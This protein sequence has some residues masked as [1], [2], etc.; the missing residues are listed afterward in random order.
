MEAAVPVPVRETVWGLPLALSA[1]LSVAVRAPMAAGVKVKSTVALAFGATLM[2]DAVVDANSA[3]LAPVIEMLEI[4][5]FAFPVLVMVTDLA[6]PVV[7]TNCCPNVMLAGLRLALGAVPV[8]ESVTACGLPAALSVTV[9]SA[10]SE[11]PVE[12]VNVTAIVVFAPGRTVT[13]NVA[14]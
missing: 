5:R 7:P 6:A 12:G 10:D 3:A 1:M 4:T 14:G 2:G 11:L 8:P 9:S 13:G